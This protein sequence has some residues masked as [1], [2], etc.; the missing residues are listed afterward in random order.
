MWD[1]RGTFHYRKYP[2][3]AVKTPMLHWGQATMFKALSQL[4][5]ALLEERRHP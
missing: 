5:V 2:L 4:Y 3:V 1:D